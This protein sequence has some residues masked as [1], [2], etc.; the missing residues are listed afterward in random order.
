MSKDILP[1]PLSAF[2]T[3]AE[4]AEMSLSLDAGLTWP[5][6]RANNT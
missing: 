3:T 2:P 6:R 4:T 1:F 5:G